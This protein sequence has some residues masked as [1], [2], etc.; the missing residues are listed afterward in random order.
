MG[1]KFRALGGIG[2]QVSGF[3]FK[4]T[5]LRAWGYKFRVYVSRRRVL[6]KLYA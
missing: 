2:L 6:G 5:R 1:F 4:I 3:G